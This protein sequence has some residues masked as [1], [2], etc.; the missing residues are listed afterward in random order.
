MV[1]KM[2]ILIVEDLPSDAELAEREISKEISPCE[3][4]RVDTQDEY[5]Q[6]L[7]EFK[8]ELIVS[9][10][11]MP[12]FD[13]MTALKLAL[14]Y[15]PEVPFIVLTGSMNEETAVEC[16]KAGAWDYVIKE[17][18]KRLVPAVRSALEQKEVN[19]KH[20]EAEERIE[21]LNR[22]LQAIRNVN[23]FI[24]REKDKTR[25]IQKVCDCLVESRGYM[26]AWIVLLR[27]AGGLLD[28]A[29]AG[30]GEDFRS[31][32][33]K[34][35][36]RD[37]PFCVQKGLAKSGILAMEDTV[38]NCSGCPLKTPNSGLAC[39]TVR[40][41]HGGRTFGS[42][43]VSVPAFLAADE[44]E[45]YLFQEV[46]DDIGF[47]LYDI[48]LQELRKQD[49][50]ALQESE[51]KYRL[52]VEN[53]NE[54]IF[55]LQDGVY[56]YVNEYGLRLFARTREEL[57]GA[58]I[59]QDVHPEDRDLI[60]DRIEVRLAGNPVEDI[61]EHRIIDAHGTEKWVETRGVLSTWEGRT[62][63][64]GFA[65]EI[66]KRK[67][68]EM[69]L[70]KSRTIL[71]EAEKVA[72]LGGWEWDIQ[73]D[74]WTMSDNWLRTH[75]CSK[76]S[77][78]TAELLPITH[79]QDREK[80]HQALT[81]ASQTG[82]PYDIV[83]RIVR[84]DSG[85][86]KIIRAYGETRLD[87][88]GK[89]MKL[90]G[91][92]QDIT[93]Q[94]Q[95]KEA[96]LESEAKY[97]E[98]F[99]SIRDAIMV[100]DTNRNIIDC[101]TAFAELFGYTRDEIKSL[102][103]YAVYNDYEEFEK[104]GEEIRK[105]IGTSKFI[106]TI[107]YKKKS[108]EV[109]TGETNVFFLKNKMGEIT[110]YIGLIRD[111]TERI[112]AE[113]ERSK[114][115][116]NL[117]QA[118]KMEAIGTLAGGIAHDFNNILSSILGY[119]ELALSKTDKGS[120]IHQFLQQVLESGGRATSLVRQILHFSRQTEEEPKP[121]Q[122][123]LIVKEALKM[124]RSSSPST[125]AINESIAKDLP[126]LIADATQIHQVVM[127]LCTNAV[128]SMQD[129]GGT[130]TVCL[131]Q[132]S[133]ELQKKTAF[134]DLLPGRYVQLSVRDTGPGIPLGIK[135][136]IFDPY[137]TTKE[138]GEGTGL[139]LAMVY[140]IVQNLRG[141]ISVSSAPD[142]GA[143]FK[144]LLP[145][146]E[147]ERTFEE[148]IAAREEQ[149]PLPGG[150]GHVLFVDDEPPIVEFSKMMLENLGYRVET[151][152]SGLEA[153]ELLRADPD[154]FDLVVTDLT[155][156]HLTGDK[157]AREIHAMRPKLPIVLCSGYSTTFSPKQAEAI[158]IRAFLHKPI[159]RNELAQVIADIFKEG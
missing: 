78:T 135:D 142:Q 118:Q 156:P 155:M 75:G 31:M 37:F 97:K 89:V 4:R 112:K 50:N 81:R 17:H 133:V 22:I 120:K 35:E 128:Q 51:R 21:H 56:K 43:T 53:A 150:S 140:S 25:L 102:K 129:N 147:S 85:D 119:T 154:R 110:G 125:I 32:L 9:D 6:A 65:S 40:L 24:V 87:A 64:I 144:V 77:F 121:L 15:E 74:T 39:L 19:R 58:P 143:E 70:D 2:R 46:A 52:V 12:S 80:V 5:L 92:D 63:N 79:P 153:L 130:L 7:Q 62:A 23:Q 76:A 18:V 69:E 109:F 104:M 149:P 145:V 101:N 134:P 68:A 29:E 33:E 116:A 13:G 131:K 8:P 148:Q 94:E 107:N 146:V 38:S 95:S 36:K 98:L 115:E 30:L 28:S 26:N 3:F 27:D 152:S 90:F 10:Y 71:A 106:Y 157:L 122:M 158:G 105:N 137:F 141:S 99:N 93:A 48:E 82:E 159:R 126:I 47:A 60:K 103:T 138:K 117:R 100:A 127:N 86:V 49:K 34:L 59:M 132:T 111:V 113:E 45:Q 151:R 123:D 42:A 55:V 124:L 139:G 136:S 11:L 72:G 54:G 108:G 84:Q 57:V 16:M 91:A 44:E 61:V 41:E 83:H 67:Q 73:N 66:T 1:Q 14:E 88:S 114:L 20:R 96:L